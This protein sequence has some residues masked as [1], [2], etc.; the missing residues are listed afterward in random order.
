MMNKFN[1]GI[2]LKMFKIIK[3]KKTIDIKLYKITS[4][5]AIKFR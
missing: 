4:P 5:D 2:L 3:I 1:F